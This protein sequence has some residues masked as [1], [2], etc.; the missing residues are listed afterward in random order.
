MSTAAQPMIDLGRLDR[1]LN[2]VRTP[3]LA[4]PLLWDVI[5]ITT[6]LTFSTIYLFLP[7]IPDLAVLRERVGPRRRWFYGLLSFGWN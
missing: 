2:I 1:I 5:S 6:Y 4:S 3:H 7:L